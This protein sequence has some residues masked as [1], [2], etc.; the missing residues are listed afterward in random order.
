MPVL[1]VKSF[2]GIAPKIPA[3]YLSDTQAQ[4]AT[5]C[6]VF[7]GSLQ[8]LSGLGDTLHTLTKTGVPKTIYRFGQDTKSDT[9]YWFHWNKDV[10]VCRGQIAGD[11]SEW[12]FF[13]GDGAPKA[14]YNAIALSGQNYP[15]ETRPLG[16]A[17]PT[18]A[19][20]PLANAFTPDEYPPEI[21]LYSSHWSQMSTD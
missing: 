12:T 18:Q 7:N 21:Y 3:R 9:Q 6:P 17:A 15:A 11:A 8:P 5:N 4:V 10:D 16:L 13:T 19:C 1:T 20:T 2:G 14:T